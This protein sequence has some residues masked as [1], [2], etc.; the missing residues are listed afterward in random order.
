MAIQPIIF[1]NKNALD[2]S[3]PSVVVTASEGSTFSPF[4]QKRVNT[5]GWMTTGSVDSNNTTLTVNFVN[6]K[7]LTDIVLV[8]HNFKSYTIKYWNGT[9]YVD[10]PTVINP[11]T[12]SASVS[13]Y[14]F[15]STQCTGF[16]ITILGTQ[17]AN[18]DKKITQVI[19]TSLIG[20]LQGWP[21]IQKPT[22]NLNKRIN[23][24]LSG[25][26]NIGVNTGGFSCD[27]AVTN[28]KNSADLAIVETLY[29]LGNGFLVW[30]CGGNQTQFSSVRQ[31]YGLQD[32]FFVKCQDNYTPEY[33]AGLYVTGMNIKISLVEVST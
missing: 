23:T 2:Y 21:T 31:G 22:F 30:L 11:T 18:S 24:M 3:D 28:W 8:N 5:L 33:V 15:A 25:K 4:I 10:F 14:T 9:S 29:N 27:L 19:A 26:S 1:F 17:V 6:L 32:F 16:K 13:R 20:Q 12:D 7:T